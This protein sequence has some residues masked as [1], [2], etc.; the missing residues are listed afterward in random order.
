MQTEV[1]GRWATD[2]IAA[3]KNWFNFYFLDSISR[4]LYGQFPIKFSAIEAVGCIRKRIYTCPLH[5][6]LSKE[7]LV[8]CC[9]TWV[10]IFHPSR[11]S[12]VSPM[13]VHISQPTQLPFLR[14]PPLFPYSDWPSM[15]SIV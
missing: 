1:V 6:S 2:R 15:P 12:N 13:M 9:S 14:C 7:V 4:P 5:R 11:S 8:I 10:S 3:K